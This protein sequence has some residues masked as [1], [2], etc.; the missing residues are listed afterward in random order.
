MDEGEL[1]RLMKR[2]IL[3]SYRWQEDVV[4]P[5][6]RELEID[7]EE[8]QDILMDK[9]D[10]SSLEAL[11]P[12][13]ESARPRCIREKLH[14]DLQLCWLVDV[15]EIISVDD[16]EAL[17]D[18]ITELVLAGREYSEALSEGRR[19]LHEILRS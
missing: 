15:M 16:A 2:R 3:E 13:F 8:F 19:R 9:L 11:H 17:K 5:L 6:S 12:R 7:V 10:M 18:E 14:S 4:K 1:M